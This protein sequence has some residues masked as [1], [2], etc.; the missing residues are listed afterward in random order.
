MSRKAA[1][2]FGNLV[3]QAD[4]NTVRLELVSYV[5]GQPYATFTR[6]EIAQLLDILTPYAS[7]RQEEPDDEVWKD[8]I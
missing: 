2:G 6:R 7:H 5:E 3:I 4:A 1:Q 8:L